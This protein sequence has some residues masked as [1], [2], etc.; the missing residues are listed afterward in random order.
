MYDTWLCDRKPRAVMNSKAFYETYIFNNNQQGL[1]LELECWL[2]N[3]GKDFI[4]KQKR[5]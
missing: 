5:N 2:V 1:G 3:I 4:H